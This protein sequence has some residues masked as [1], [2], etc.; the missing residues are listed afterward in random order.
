MKNSLRCMTENNKKRDVHPIAKRALE[1]AYTGINPIQFDDYA[2]EQLEDM[3]KEHFDKPDLLKAAVDLINLA[4]ILKAEGCNSTSR[5]LIIVASTA[6][7]A[8]Q[9]QK[10]KSSH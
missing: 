2:I 9:E 4:S 5:K 1:I 3:L 10:K 8:L 6:T 7:D